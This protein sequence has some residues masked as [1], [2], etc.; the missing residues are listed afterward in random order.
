MGKVS[1]Q[2]A[3]FRVLA[4]KE[5]DNKS[6]GE[7][8]EDISE[9]EATPSLAALPKGF[10]KA[11]TVLC[12]FRP[13]NRVVGCRQNCEF[14]AEKFRFL[15]HR[16]TQLRQRRPVS[17]ILVTSSV[18][19]EGK[20]LVAVNLAV[21]LASNYCRVAL[22][23]ADLR[24]P[25]AQ[26]TLGLPPSA[27]LAEF[28]EGKAGLDSVMHRVDPLGFYCLA[29]GKASGNPFELLAGRRMG[30]LVR[31][32]ATAFEWVVIDSPPLIPFA[33][34]HHL[35]GLV[36][37]VLLVARPGVTPRDT[38]KQAMSALDSVQIVG[39]VL[40][41]SDDSGQ[42]GYYYHYYPRASG[43]GNGSPRWPTLSLKAK[44]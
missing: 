26:S 16:L 28:L 15:R 29:A 43:H 30:Q 5:A 18:P 24:H 31:L 7:L 25:S 12:H 11:T 1:Q 42:D 27:G 19:K 36:D 13:K 44:Q 39:V 21:S 22:F 9:M 33:D 4:Q 41:G 20:T 10:E 3:G 37:V 35:A 14:G 32:A 2:F 8:F 38:L 6:E 34:A 40:N 23:D 17:K